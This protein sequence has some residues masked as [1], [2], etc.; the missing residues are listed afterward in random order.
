MDLREPPEEAVEYLSRT[1]ELEG[2]LSNRGSY[3]GLKLAEA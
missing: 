1:Y 3:A 2:S